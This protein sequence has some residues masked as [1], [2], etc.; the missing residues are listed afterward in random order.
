MQT[1]S[2]PSDCPEYVRCEAPICPLDRDWM[3]RVYHKGEATCLFLR[4][5]MKEGAAER[6]AVNPAFAELHSLAII[7]FKA[8]EAVATART[9]AGMPRGRGDHIRSIRQAADTGSVLDSRAAAGERLAATRKAKAEA[10]D[11]GAA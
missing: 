2:Q 10:R 6:L 4:E 1:L 11:A 8:E 3:L 9:E 5:S 7:W